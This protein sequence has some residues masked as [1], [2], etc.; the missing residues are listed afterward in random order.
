[1]LYH[2]I[3]VFALALVGLLR[4]GGFAGKSLD[5]AATCFLLGMLLFSGSLYLMGVTG[6]KK[7]GMITPLGG[8]LLLCGWVMVA[9]SQAPE[10]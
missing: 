9:I 6:W 2:V 4:M 10:R 1:V 7:L 3:H 5:W 8:L